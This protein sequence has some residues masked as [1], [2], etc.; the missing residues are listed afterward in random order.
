MVGAMA[1]QTEAMMKTTNETSSS[2]LRPSASP[3]RP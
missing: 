1:Q 3:N 2:F